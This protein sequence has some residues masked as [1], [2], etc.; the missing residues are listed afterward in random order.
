MAQRPS[1]LW[2]VGFFR[3]AIPGLRGAS[4]FWDLRGP[5]PRPG[6][7]H[8]G[9]EHSRR[10]LSALFSGRPRDPYFYCGLVGLLLLCLL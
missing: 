9:S 1:L 2:L 10:E 5:A 4:Q 6:G 3:H 8:R 7:L